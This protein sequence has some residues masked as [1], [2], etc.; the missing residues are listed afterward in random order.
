M[1]AILLAAG[2]SSRLDP[3]GDK[4]LLDF[5]GKTLVERQVLLIK[6]A[7]I[8]DV[9][10]VGNAANLPALKRI[11]KKYNSVAVTE[12]KYLAEGMAGGVLAGAK[13]VN[14]QSILV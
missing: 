13:R 1:Q 2:K 10:V 12:Q 3:L 8:R 11:F 7:K 14:Q 5:C 9:V 6:N 4:N